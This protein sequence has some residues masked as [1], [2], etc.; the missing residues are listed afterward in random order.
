MATQQPAA[1]RS[2]GAIRFPRLG[3]TFEEERREQASKVYNGPPSLPEYWAPSPQETKEIASGG[4]TT[5]CGTMLLV[6]GSSLAVVA[7]ARADHAP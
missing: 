6:S 1:G 2:H 4:W 3:P 7:D 5:A